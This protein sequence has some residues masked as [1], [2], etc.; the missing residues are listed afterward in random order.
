VKIKFGIIDDN[1]T[2]IESLQYFINEVQVDGISLEQVFIKH[3][4]DVDSAEDEE[5]IN[6]VDLLF[7]DIMLKRKN[8]L[9]IIKNYQEVEPVVVIT[10]GHDGHMLKAIRL[11]AFDYLMKPID[12]EDF[13]EMLERVRERIN[14]ELT[15]MREWISLSN[16]I[17]ENHL[18]EEQA[19][20]I[21]GIHGQEKHKPYGAF[22]NQ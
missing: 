20:K 12:E 11:E 13:I 3:D 15:R 5:Q 7:L 9:D 19:K 2:A 16:A 1:P 14:R 8:S 18:T 4:L 21:A 6:S 17:N 22:A 10:T